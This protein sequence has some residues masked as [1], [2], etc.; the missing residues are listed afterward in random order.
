MPLCWHWAKHT[1]NKYFSLFSNFYSLFQ[2]ITTN[3]RKAAMPLSRSS[4]QSSCNATFLKPEV[5]SCAHF[6]FA[7]F[8][9][10]FVKYLSITKFDFLAALHDNATFQKCHSHFLEPPSISPQCHFVQHTA[11]HTL[12]K[13]FSLSF[14]IFILYSNPFPKEQQKTMF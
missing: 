13:Y 11:T 14:L 12:D 10:F 5:F 8:F 1:L 9:L 4:R 7:S 6:F 2:L 3:Q